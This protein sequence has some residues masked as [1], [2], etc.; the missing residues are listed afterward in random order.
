MEKKKKISKMFHQFIKI[1]GR[2]VKT[3]ASPPEATE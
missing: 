2:F 1:N 3:S